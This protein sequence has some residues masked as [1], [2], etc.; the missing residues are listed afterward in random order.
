MDVAAQIAQHFNS[1]SPPRVQN[2]HVGDKA[3]LYQSFK[4]TVELR[5]DI[6]AKGAF[7]S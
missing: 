1:R 5:I 4:N 3:Q 6:C 2:K 7:S